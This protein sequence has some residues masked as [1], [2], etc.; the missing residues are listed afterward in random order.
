MRVGIL[1]LFL[2]ESLV[3]LWGCDQKI[4]TTSNG[5]KFTIEYDHQINYDVLNAEENLVKNAF[6]SANTT[7]DFKYD[8]TD[9]PN[10]WVRIDSL[11]EY[12]ISH[13]KRDSTGSVMYPGYLCSIWRVC[14]EYGFPVDEYWGY[15]YYPPEPRVGHSFIVQGNPYLPI[16]CWAKTIIHE[17]GHQRC[18]VTHLCLDDTTMNPAHDDSA[19]VMGK[20]ATAICT[21]WDLCNDPHFCGACCNSISNVSW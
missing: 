3:L 9:L 6:T 12:Y 8:D 16:R 13:V 11:Y 19:C 10:C 4:P 20:D 21:G 2:L 18:I 1:I 7:L 14:D 17:L 15:T 5:R